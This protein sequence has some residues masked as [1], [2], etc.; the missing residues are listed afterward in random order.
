MFIYHFFVKIRIYH[1]FKNL[2]SGNF[3]FVL[4][5]FAPNAEHWFSGQHALSGRRTTAEKI[6]LWYLRLSNIFRG[7]QFE[8]LQLLVSGTPWNTRVVVEWKDYVP[9]KNGSPLPNQG[10]F[11]IRLSWG[12][13]TEFHVYCDTQKIEKNLMILASQGVTEATAPPIEN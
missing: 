1:I 7:I 11:M 9:D 10:V 13:A 5:Q 4:Q 12:K 8:I 6:K 3:D 2:N